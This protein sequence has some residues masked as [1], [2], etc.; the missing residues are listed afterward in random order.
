MDDAFYEFGR[1]HPGF[2]GVTMRADGAL[3]A[4]FVGEPSASA[5]EVEALAAAV[6]GPPARGR[7]IAFAAA[8]RDFV[9][10]YE[11]LRRVIEVANPDWLSRFGIDEA[12]GRLS[13]GAVDA[14][15]AAALRDIVR[16]DVPV[17]IT[18]EERAVADQGL[19]GLFRPTLGG[20]R[21]TVGGGGCSIAGNASS[22]P[23]LETGWWS[24]PQYVLSAAHCTSSFGALTGDAL[25]QP[26]VDLVAFEVADEPFKTRTQIGDWRCPASA[27]AT[28]RYADVAVFE[29]A[30]GGIA[31]YPY[32]VIAATPNADPTTVSFGWTILQQWGHI[33]MGLGV[34]KTGASTG[35]TF[36]YV[37]HTCETIAFLNRWILCV[38]GAP[39]GSQGGDSGG[40][41]VGGG[42]GTDNYHA[43]VHFARNNATGMRWF[44]PHSNIALDMTYFPGSFG[45][46]LLTFTCWN[47]SATS[48]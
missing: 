34:V 15:A 39:Y 21:V 1:T 26:L 35:S 32:P 33:P 4:S 28:C 16:K 48:C 24:S 43:G 2:G 7:K 20:T 44:S 36:G 12:R 6:F 22:V 30:G 25:Y 27:G 47:G 3:V 31:A 37:Q 10:L 29:M 46:L 8:S 17:D 5:S 40:S 9:S 23:F 42:V 38:S 45:R 41:V 14:R 11:E 18:L 13:F 19:S